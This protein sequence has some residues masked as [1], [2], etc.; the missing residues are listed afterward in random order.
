M[1]YSGQTIDMRA[2]GACTHQVLI[3]AVEL[4]TLPTPRP[5]KTPC[6]IVCVTVGGSS[7]DHVSSLTLSHNPTRTSI[8]SGLV[9]SGPDLSHVDSDGALHGEELSRVDHCAVVVMSA[10]MDYYFSSA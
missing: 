1:F 10:V 9:K 6:G 8:G 3:F 7:C 4:L 2:G 5:L